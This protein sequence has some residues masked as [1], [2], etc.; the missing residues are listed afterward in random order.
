MNVRR[1]S[2]MMGPMMG[3]KGETVKGVVAPRGAKYGGNKPGP[4]KNSVAVQPEVKGLS[5]IRGAVS[6]PNKH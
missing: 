3:D 5:K 6:W 2:G 1:R 4:I